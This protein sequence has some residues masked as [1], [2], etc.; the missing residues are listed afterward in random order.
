M[1]D[2]R[3]KQKQKEDGWR[4]WGLGKSLDDKN[5]AKGEEEGRDGRVKLEIYWY[6][7]SKQGDWKPG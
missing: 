5:V 4:Q 7:N 6:N 1:G 2:E 3:Q